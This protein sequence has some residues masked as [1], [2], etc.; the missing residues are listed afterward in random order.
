MKPLT[1]SLLFAI[2][3]LPFTASAAVEVSAEAFSAAGP[4]YYAAGWRTEP[5]ENWASACAGGA[6]VSTFVHASAVYLQSYYAQGNNGTYPGGGGSAT[7]LGR[8]WLTITPTGTGGASFVDAA[9]HLSLIGAP[10]LSA[11]TASSAISTVRVSVDGAGNSAW[12]QESA[13]VNMSVPGPQASAM[14][15][16]D[17]DEIGATL[18]HLPVG[19]PFQLQLSLDSSGN[20]AGSANSSMVGN[21]R[22]SFDEHQPVFT[23]PAGYT[24]NSQDWTIQGNQFCPNGCAPVPEPSAWLTMTFG[25]VLLPWAARRNRLVRAFLSDHLGEPA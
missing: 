4:G 17:A 10:N 20:A 16:V 18:L 8:G 11:G 2:A 24:V 19:Q 15:R 3:A 6:C 5:I 13:A 25:L 1:N 22:L 14:W 21:Y 23:L 9:L 7:T 12:L